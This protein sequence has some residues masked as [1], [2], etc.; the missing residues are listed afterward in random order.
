MPSNLTSPRGPPSL[1]PLCLPLSP[2][3]TLFSST[4]A[5]CTK[6]YSALEELIDSFYSSLF[7]P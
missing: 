1:L 6:S 5:D 2:D 3:N 4:D 7:T